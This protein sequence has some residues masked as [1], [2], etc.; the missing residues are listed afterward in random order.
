MGTDR[1][2]GLEENGIFTAR[3]ADPSGGLQDGQF[4]PGQS[5]GSPTVRCDHAQ[6]VII[7]DEGQLTDGQL[8]VAFRSEEIDAT[9]RQGEREREAGRG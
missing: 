5:R 3:S 1:A 2:R 7:D 6:T 4:R 9:E 8:A